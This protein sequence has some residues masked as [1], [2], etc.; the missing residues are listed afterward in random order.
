MGFI[1]NPLWMDMGILGLSGG[2]V[3][4]VQI[5]VQFLPEGSFLIL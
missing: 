4:E 3:N 5:V 1:T 2:R